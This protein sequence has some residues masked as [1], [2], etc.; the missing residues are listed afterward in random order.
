VLSTASVPLTYFL[1]ARV[2][3][4]AAGVVAAALLAFAPFAVFYGTEARP[5]A[6]L[7]FL[8]ALSTLLLLRALEARGAGWWLVYAVSGCALLYTQYTGI[9]VLVAH[10]AWAIWAHRDRLGAFGLAQLAILA[11][12][13]PWLSTV[14]SKDASVTDFGRSFSLTVA[15]D[16]TA[17]VLP[18]HPYEAPGDLPGPVLLALW[19]LALLAGFTAALWRWRRAR[20]GALLAQRLLLLAT[21][22]LTLLAGLVAYSVVETNIFL[23][24]NLSAAL[25]AVA[26]LA[27]WALTSGTRRT[28]VALTVVALAVITTAAVQGQDV[29][30]R[31]TNARAAAEYIDSH[32]R[33]GEP[34]LLVPAPFSPR[35]PL[36][37]G[38]PIYFTQPHP[39]VRAGRDDERAWEQGLRG[40]RVFYFFADIRTLLSVRSLQREFGPGKCFRLE[41][42]KVVGGSVRLI[43]GVY[44]LEPAQV[45]CAQ[46]AL[47]GP[48]ALDVPVRLIRGGGATVIANWWEGE[49]EVRPGSVPGFVENV[50]DSEDGLLLTGWAA[51]LRNRVPA[52]WVLLFEGR[53]L[54]AA[55][56]PDV[57]RIDLVTS[58]GLREPRAGFRLVVPGRSMREIADLS[59]LRVVA[60]KAPRASKLELLPPAAAALSGS[61][62]QSGSP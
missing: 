53:R 43:I 7:T 9:F 13:S 6:S 18:G 40:K 33:P 48:R 55:A 57:A 3:G 23:P 29:R 52:D 62:H 35:G 46:L 16:R 21:I 37:R 24:R 8:A 58:Q 27:G 60:V 39:T 15:V 30:V 50:Q 26:V 1:G 56:A 28:A 11:G 12:Y 41:M 10:A 17:R 59:R 44:G 22:F 54:L 4:R 61:R 34:V 25:P 38:L 32:A 45:A 47:H 49:P 42:S 51:D 20:T 2:A 14:L 5:Y 31:G 36:S 19:C